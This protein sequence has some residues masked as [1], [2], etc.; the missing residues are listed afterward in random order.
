MG[1]GFSGC[2]L[3]RLIAEHTDCKI[4]IF[5]ARSHLG[6]N[7]HTKRCPETSNLEHVYGPHI[8]HTSDADV[9]A[10]VNRFAKFIPFKNQ[11][12]AHTK[13]GIFSM[14]INLH[15]INQLF[16][17]TFSP[18]EAKQYIDSVAI[19]IND[20]KNFEEQAL[21]M[22][23]EKIYST[24]F[25]GYT[26][27]QWGRSPKE[28]PASILKRL[29]LRFT[30]DDNYYNCPH[31][32]LPENGYTALMEGMIDHPRIQCHLGAKCDSSI[33]EQYDHVYWSGPIDAYFNYS[34]GR[35]RYRTVTFK[36]S[37]TCAVGQGNAV[38]NYPDEHVPFT[39]VHQHNYFAP[40][41]NHDKG[42]LIH[43]FSKE[44]S[45]EDEPYY[46]LRLQEDLSLYEQYCKLH[47]FPSK[48]TFI[49]RL[50]TY[51]YLDMDKVIK[52]AM[53]VFQKHLKEKLY[54]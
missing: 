41:E 7:C 27:K 34:K 37:H 47:T 11:V 2:T 33:I 17:R 5:D 30:Y 18:F 54:H 4:D 36:K 1:A 3:A 12:K 28:L 49:G 44:T 19:P 38:I 50:G 31:Q 9:W 40:W 16:N 29:P 35:L 42:L 39:R 25:Y 48:L 13:N 22:V 20:P 24:F 45:E 32:G 21:S 26:K 52:K 43:E 51:A 15:T 6:G 23:G 8:F 14:P 46:P 53:D 10:F